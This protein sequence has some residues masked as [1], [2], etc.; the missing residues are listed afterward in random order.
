[1]SSKILMSVRAARY[2]AAFGVA[3]MSFG[4]VSAEADQSANDAT[5]TNSATTVIGYSDLD[6]SN[7]S[8]VRSLYVRLQTAARQV[9]SDYK[10]MRNLRLRSRYESCYQ[11]SLARA[12]EEV[13]HASVTAIF[14]ADERIRMA[15]PSAKG[16]ASS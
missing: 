14:T 3:A 6:L 12:V 9:C 2:V 8:D 11:E 10:D 1:M 5:S 4:A 13:D 7:A 16:K 15:G